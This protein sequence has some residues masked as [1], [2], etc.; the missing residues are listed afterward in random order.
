MV[1]TT[2]VLVCVAGGTCASRLGVLWRLRALRLLVPLDDAWSVVG[3]GER[4]RFL[5]TVILLKHSS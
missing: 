2:T 1:L 3:L 5:F 4:L